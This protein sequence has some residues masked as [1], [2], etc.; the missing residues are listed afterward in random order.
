V[1]VVATANK[2]AGN[3][4]RI[5]GILSAGERGAQREKERAAQDKIPP[6]LHDTARSAQV[7]C[8]PLSRSIIVD[9]SGGRSLKPLQSAR[10]QT[11]NAPLANRRLLYFAIGNRLLSQHQRFRIW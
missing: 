8:G 10:S 9:A 3:S 4:F 11:M 5:S 7:E 6:K 1:T 2:I